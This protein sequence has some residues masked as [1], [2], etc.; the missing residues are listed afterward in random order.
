MEP[1]RISN[2]C[3]DESNLDL[4]GFAN[5]HFG[6]KQLKLML[7]KYTLLLSIVDLEISDLLSMKI[8]EKVFSSLFNG[9]IDNQIA[10]VS[11]LFLKQKSQVVGHSFNALVSE[12]CL[13]VSQVV[14]VGV[15]EVRVKHSFLILY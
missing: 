12:Q 9:H 1:C 7:C 14:G 8:K 13:L 6:D 15:C 4:I 5:F 3:I 10:L 2:I 11:L